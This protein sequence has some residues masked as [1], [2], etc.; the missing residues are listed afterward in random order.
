[1]DSNPGPLVT[2]ATTLPTAL[3]P[4]PKDR[5]LLFRLKSFEGHQLH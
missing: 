5:L 3:Q 2:E 1:M 4:L